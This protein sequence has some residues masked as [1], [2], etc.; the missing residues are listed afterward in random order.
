M[1]YNRPMSITICIIIIIYYTI[2]VSI[3]TI[4]LQNYDCLLA[5]I[6]LI[7]ICMYYTIPQ[8]I[9]HP[10]KIFRYKN[11][12]SNFPLLTCLKHLWLKPKSEF[13]NKKN[14]KLTLQMLDLRLLEQLWFSILGQET[15]QMY[16]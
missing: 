3:L 15:H 1:T 13:F 12:C 8:L 7:T 11:H 14:V 4:K 5:I 6:V 10:H 9:K 16:H 2:L